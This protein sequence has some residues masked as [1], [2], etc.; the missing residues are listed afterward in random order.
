MSQW[1]EFSYRYDGSYAGF[2]TCVFESY[3][4]R[5]LPEQF[6][7]AEDP[8][9]SLWPER[10]VETD[11]EKAGRV[12]RSLSR[13]ISRQAQELVTQGFLT[14]MPDKE[15]RLYEFLRLGYRV[16]PA[17]TRD[18]A[19]PR[20][21][22]VWKAVRHLAN[23]AHL[24]KGFLRFSDQGGVLVGEIAPKNRVLPLLRPHFCA[25]YSG[26][27]FVIYDQTHREALFYRPRQWA[28]LP[29][30]D[31]Q[32]GAPDQA[33]RHHRRLWRRFYDTVAIQGRENPRCRMTQMPKRY[34]STMTE[35]QEEPEEGEKF[36]PERK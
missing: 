35:F 27:T 4:R 29:L 36:L 33:E 18:L 2:L 8:R 13:R 21:A 24:L 22:A 34:W 11:R 7:T 12:Y 31:F 20:T 28:I 10:A 17:V 9:V 30:E 23:E 19:D 5:E 16:G 32:A 1:T 15:L 25:R 14:C 26:E 6:S 3:A